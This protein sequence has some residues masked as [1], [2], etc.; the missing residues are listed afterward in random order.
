MYCAHKPLKFKDRAHTPIY[1]MSKILFIII[2]T[3][4][5]ISIIIT[6]PISLALTI[7]IIAI[8]TA[9]LIALLISSW[10]AFLLF[11]IYIGGILVIFAYFVATA[12]NFPINM[13]PTILIRTL[14]IIILFIYVNNKSNTQPITSLSSSLNT[15]YSHQTIHTLTIIAF[16]LLLTIIIVIKVVS[17]PKGPLRPF[18][19]YV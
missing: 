1:K 19:K 11:L 8:L 2:T 6:N 16:L 18:S 13:K 14:I 15:F 10:I 4:A 5:S 9:L 7:L 17:L 3:T 12:P